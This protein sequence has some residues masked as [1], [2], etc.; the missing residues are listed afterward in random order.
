M[1]KRLLFILL[2]FASASSAQTQRGNWLRYQLFDKC[3]PTSKLAFLNADT[4][5]VVLRYLGSTPLISCITQDGGRTWD[6]IQYPNGAPIGRLYPFRKS[7]YISAGSTVEY[8]SRDGKEWTLHQD[9]FFFRYLTRSYPISFDSTVAIMSYMDS[10]RLFLSVDTGNTFTDLGFAFRA[11]SIADGASQS[12]SDIVLSIQSSG[13]FQTIFYLSDTGWVENV[14]ADTSTGFKWVELNP[15]VAGAKKGQFFVLG[16]KIDSA[17][18]IFGRVT[19]YYETKDGGRSWTAINSVAEGRVVLLAN[20]E[21]NFIVVAVGH[22]RYSHLE[23]NNIVNSV[24]KQRGIPE[25][26]IDSIFISTD[27]GTT[28]QKD[29][30]SFA[31]D[32]IVGMYWVSSKV[33]YVISYRDS[34]SYLSRYNSQ[35]GAVIDHS[36]PNPKWMNLSPNPASSYIT[37]TN[38][39]LDAN[40]IRIV[41]TLGEIVYSEQ[42]RMGYKEI[43]RLNLP[44]FLLPGCYCLCTSSGNGLVGKSFIKF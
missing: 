40:E 15:V 19:D 42:R 26:W 3:L 21:P 28:W 2:I 34:T 30:T 37:F 22:I 11:A 24:N 32:T 35:Q 9:P 14:L 36:G 43:C 1:N 6:T 7:G 33:G 38:Y 4:G 16:G 8:S 31:G 5:V 39:L 41:N 23:Y 10:S 20:P 29:G 12:P 18:G 13:L 44:D 17:N 25:K 27:G